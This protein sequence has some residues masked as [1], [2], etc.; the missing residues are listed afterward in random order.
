[1][2]VATAFLMQGQYTEAIAMTGRNG[3]KVYVDGV[4]AV[5]F[6]VDLVLL[7]GTNQMSGFPCRKR[8]LV[9]A[10][11]FGALYSG[12]CLLPQIRFLG[13][14]LWRVVSLGLMGSI[15]YGWS[16]SALARC[17]LFCMLSLALGGLATAMGRSDIQALLLSAAGLWCICCLVSVSPPGSREY[18]SL[19]IQNGNRSVSLLALRDTG[20]T[21]RD[22]ITGQQALVLSL[23]ASSRLT[24]L[25]PLQI[26]DPLA[27]MVSNPIPGLRVLPYRTV[28]QSGG[29]ML[30]MVFDHVVVDGRKQKALVAFSPENFGENGVW[31]A[32]TG[33]L[34]SW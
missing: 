33:G 31:Q 28:G 13:N 2:P 21:L 9:A 10:A 11:L 34:T 4:M 24:G 26:Q 8:R 18:V 15:A 32:L 7:I 20:N 16:R 3:L 30:A 19:Q 25:T 23:S 6:A 17:G 27:T 5:N 1:M 29:M 12:A 22:P 14:I